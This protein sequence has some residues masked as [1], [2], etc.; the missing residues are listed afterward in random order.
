MLEKADL[1]QITSVDLELVS[2]RVNSTCKAN[3]RN[4]TEDTQAKNEKEKKT[5]PHSEGP[6]DA[7]C[8][9]VA[10][11]GKIILCAFCDFSV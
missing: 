1:P 10:K 4:N 5:G 2:P 8:G 11:M 7:K 3:T 9:A 6:A